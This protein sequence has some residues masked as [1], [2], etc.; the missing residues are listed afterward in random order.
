MPTNLN[1]VSMKPLRGSALVVFPPI[2]FLWWWITFSVVTVV[3]SLNR[4]PGVH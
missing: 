2:S 3:L 4:R 1:I